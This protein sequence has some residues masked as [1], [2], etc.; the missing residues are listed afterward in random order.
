MRASSTIAMAAA[1][2]LAIACAATP[3][4]TLAAAPRDVLPNLVELPPTD[5]AV[6]V[7]EQPD[8]S[9]RYELRFTSIAG[10]S[11]AGALE[12]RSTRRS[13][14]A[15][16]TS[17]QAVA[18]AGGGARTAP[19]PITIG[20]DDDPGHGHFHI[21]R[22]ER[23]ELTSAQG[24]IAR[25]SK[26]GYCLGDRTLLGTKPAKQRFATACRGRQPGALS[27]AQGI[28][29]GWADPYAADLPGQAFD[30]TGLPDGT[31][32][33]VNRVNDQRLYLESSY[34]DNVAATVFRLSRP[35]GAAAAPH[36]EQVTTCLAERCSQRG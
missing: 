14:L 25:D 16:W 36:V 11:G 13:S 1:T 7:I 26:A 19:L 22:F 5:L 12:V 18:L 9:S 3:A 30:L 34:A 23:Y 31:Y 8:G 6:A 32:T 10:N 20:Y 24:V 4:A 21:A 28:S 27:L 33:L 15:P 2:A 17:V 29:P 35:D